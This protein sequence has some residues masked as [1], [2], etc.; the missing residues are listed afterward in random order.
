[1][2]LFRRLLVPHDFSAPANRALALAT[3]LAREHGGQLLVLHVIMPFQ[4]ITGFPVISMPLLPADLVGGQLRRLQALVAR[5]VRGRDAPR[6]ECKVV[7]G[8]PFQQIAA[9]ARGVD[10]IVMSTA[11]RSGLAHVLIGS[12]AEKVVRHAP[13]PVLT[14]R[15]TARPHRRAGGR[16]RR[17]TSTRRR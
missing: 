4:P 8:D 3:E 6:I 11:G 1:M 17:A 16:R 2:T 5:L 15:P 10:A 13:C 14:L 12:V 7:V 9:A